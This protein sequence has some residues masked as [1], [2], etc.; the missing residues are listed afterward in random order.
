MAM[1]SKGPCHGGAGSRPVDFWR[2]HQRRLG[3]PASQDD[4]ESSGGSDA[5]GERHA[6]HFGIAAG[7]VRDVRAHAQCK[8]RLAVA[9]GEHAHG[10]VRSKPSS[11]HHV[12]FHQLD[13][14]GARVLDGRDGLHVRKGWRHGEGSTAGAQLCTGVAHHVDERVHSA[15]CAQQLRLEPEG[16]DGGEARDHDRQ[17]DGSA[18]HRSFEECFRP[19]VSAFRRRVAP[20]ARRAEPAGDHANCRAGDWN[21]G[22]KVAEAARGVNGPLLWPWLGR[23]TPPH[24]GQKGVAC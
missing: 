21:Q 7:D 3:W 22:R 9:Q 23:R 24:A 20:P 14:G 1:C 8:L 15:A 6:R 2:D 18:G 5:T 13:A 10:N 4:D 19:G 16:V 12:H 11:G 17:D